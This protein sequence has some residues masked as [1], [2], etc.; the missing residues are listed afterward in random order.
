[1]KKIEK[2]MIWGLRGFKKKWVLRKSKYANIPN[3]SPIS[4]ET[5]L[6]RVKFLDP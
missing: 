4:S 6:G 2:M 5:M 1:M 3:E